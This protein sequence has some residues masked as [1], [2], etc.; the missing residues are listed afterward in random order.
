MYISL[1]TQIDLIKIVTKNRFFVIKLN[2]SFINYGDLFERNV[3]NNLGVVGEDPVGEKP[4]HYV[5]VGP[6]R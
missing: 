6:H 5:K 3:S 2:N 1:W 4:Q